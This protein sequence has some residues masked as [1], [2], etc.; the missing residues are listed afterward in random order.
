M[1][2]GLRKRFEF[3]LVCYCDVDL[4]GDKVERKSTNDAYQFLGK[5]LVFQRN[6]A[7]LPYQPWKFCMS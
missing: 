3:D 1:T 6:K 5:S 7:Q 4:V 2:F